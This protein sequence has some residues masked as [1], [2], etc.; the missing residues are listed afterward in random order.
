MRRLRARRRDAQ[1]PREG[2]PSDA[3]AHNAS[4]AHTGDDER[5]LGAA[6]GHV[7][8]GAPLAPIAALLREGCDL[9]VLPTI[10]VAGADALLHVCAQIFLSSFVAW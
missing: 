3:H 5:L 7:E 1:M 2:S 10:M 4:D 9:D 8:L 6:Q